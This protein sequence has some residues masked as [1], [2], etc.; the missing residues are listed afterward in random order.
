MQAR[1]SPLLALTLCFG[2]AFAGCKDD[3]PEIP[4]CVTDMDCRTGERCAP[5]G[6]CIFGAECVQEEECVAQDPRTFCNVEDFTCD[7]RDGFADECDATRPCAFGQF[8][9]D[10]L[11]R[12]LDANTAKDCVR[13]SQCPANQICDRTANKCIADPGCYGDNF[14][15]DGEICDAV[16]QLCRSVALECTSCAATGSCESI[17]NLCFVDTKECL[18]SGAQPACDDG[19]QCD[20]L[21][22][23]VQ[24][25]RSA[26]CGPG[27]FCNVSV[28]R[29]E[30]NVQC[31]DDPT[32]CPMSAEV[33][34]IT[35]ESPQM[36]NQRTRRCEAPPEPCQEDIECPTEQ[37]CDVS[38]DPPICIPRVPDCLNDLLDEPRNDIVATAALLSVDAGPR[39]EELKSC[40]G[41]LDWYRLDVQAGTY[42]T[43]DARFDNN[44]GDLDMQLFLADGRT[45]LD[46]SRSVTDNERLELEVGT[47]LTLFV[48][49]FFA[50]PSVQPVS[51]ELIVA[52][53]PGDL[54]MDDAHEP[55]DL[56]ADAKQ[57]LN[58]RP[59]EGRLCPGDPDWFAL[60]NVPVGSR[61]TLD[62]DFI[63][64]LGDLDLEVYRSNQSQALLSSL[65]TNDDEALAFDAPF[66][67]DFFV[68]VFGKSADTN[69]YAL[70]AA[71][72]A[73]MGA[74]C[75]DD[76]WEPNDS[77]TTTIDALTLI[78]PQSLTLCQGDE[79]WFSFRL[80]PGDSVEI[81][82]G[83]EPG[84][85]LELKVYPADITD[86]D[87]TPIEQA[88]TTNPREF[89]AFRTFTGGDFLVRVHGHTAQ[90]ISPYDFRIDISPRVLCQ[91]DLVDV[92]GQGDSMNAAFNLPLPPMR[93]DDLTLC[94]GDTQD[95]YR[96]FAQAGFM[97]VISTHYNPDDGQ[98]D[99]ELLLADGSLLFS[100]AT[101]PATIPRQVQI[102]VPGEVGFALLFM[103]VFPTIGFDPTYRITHDL[104]PIYSCN[105]D[106]A[107]SN[108]LRTFASD[109]A[110]STV[111]P[112]LVEGL[113]LCAGT[114]DINNAGDTDWYILTP[115][116]VGARIEAQIDFAQ[117]D[118]LMELLGPNGGPRA[119]T[120]Q[121]ED[122]CYSD[123]LGL[124]ERISFTATTTDPYFLRV[125]SA[126]SSPNVQI[127]PPNS[128][129]A[130]DLQ[131]IYDQP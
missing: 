98:I 114:R 39:Y 62:L 13:R 31:A 64:N 131:I 11:G 88:T 20:P 128:D 111:S 110:S 79:D 65:T 107:E 2:A 7:F 73:G 89:I 121:G 22:R 109:V 74:T 28:G 61:V 8:C 26:D 70:R 116:E 47:D 122:R 120:N 18:P 63:D 43:V 56:R 60:R 15:E 126:Y 38:Q 55:D 24:C 80:E 104:V 41:D 92:S 68:R 44:D 52:R 113:T 119:C 50:A 37:L 5:S 19:E 82:A 27:L 112:V 67:G 46:E 45:L 103:R 84:S 40:P 101:L 14:C 3:P 57:L 53:D 48:K 35:C 129:T 32:L 127:R 108:N 16:N 29:C 125:D 130:Y 36:C 100:T 9:S 21:G 49:V 118:L 106:F 99:F 12:C 54:C 66:G 4:P 33:T 76:T 17:R 59:Y 95:W 10:L 75:A 115:P 83:F 123:G 91:A 97:N 51:Y 1:L 105:P 85:D 25:S 124:S 94:T 86:P 93:Q 96:V 71:I 117:G 58:D 30:S 81:E 72:R 6:L 90:D 42:L 77:P 102:N 78:G 69:V 34:C 87:V 23:C